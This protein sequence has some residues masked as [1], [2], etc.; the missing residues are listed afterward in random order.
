MTVHA[1]AASFLAVV[2]MHGAQVLASYESIEL[3]EGESVAHLV[4]DVVAG[5]EGVAGVYADAYTALVVHA[6]D[7][8]CYLSEGVPEVGALPGG[9]LY[10]GAYLHGLAEG[11]V[12]L[13]GYLVE[14]L[15]LAYLVEV[16]TRVEVE[17]GQPQ[18][19]AARHLV[20]EGVAAFQQ[21]L[22]VGASEV[23]EVAVV[24]Q[25]EAWLEASFGEERLEGCYLVGSE[26]LARPRPLVAC[27]EC[28][29]VGSD[30]FGV[31]DSVA[32][33][34]RCADMCSDMFCHNFIAFEVND[35]KFTLFLSNR[36]FSY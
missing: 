4:A 14:A 29:G 3:V 11:E 19:V 2:E 5:G 7:D 35:C 23:D 36:G 33:A 20:E 16:R 24:W 18:L 15:L 1:A 8:A 26:W 21:V 28:E 25:H 31:E 30:G 6:T 27:E 13:L 10:H 17:H 22:L 34:A 9:V 12:N 32:D